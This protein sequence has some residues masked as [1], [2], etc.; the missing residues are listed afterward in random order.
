MMNH[1]YL[2][3]KVK[4]FVNDLISYQQGK[5]SYHKVAYSDKEELTALLI[6]AAGKDGEREFLTESDHLDQVI[7]AFRKYM[8]GLES[9]QYFL[10]AMK[11]NA[12][13]YF[14]DTM[15][16]IFNHMLDEQVNEHNTWLDRFDRST[17]H[18]YT[19]RSA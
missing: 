11:G 13:A 3:R 17:G 16:E 19:E 18:H 1:I 10:E 4:S 12:V 6:E 5:P 7:G 9:D 15:Q 8:L 2:T 14:E